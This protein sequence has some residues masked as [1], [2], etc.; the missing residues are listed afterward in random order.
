MALLLLN[1][2]TGYH[3]GIDWMSWNVGE[4][5][6]GVSN[7]PEGIHYIY[8]SA[9]ELRG[10]DCSTRS[11]KFIHFN[12]NQIHVWTWNTELETCLELEP[13]EA[14]KYQDGANRHEFDTNLGP[15]PIEHHKKWISLTNHIT[16]IT[17]NRLSPVQFTVAAAAATPT[18]TETET[19]SKSTQN[20]HQS[21]GRSFYTKL[22]GRRPTIIKNASDVTKYAFDRTQALSEVLHAIQTT[23]T[24]SYQGDEDLAMNELL[25]ELEYSFISFIVGQTAD[26]LEQWKSL[27]D[28]LCRC[29]DA[30]DGK[31]AEG[32]PLIPKA[33]FIVL[34][35]MLMAQLIEVPEDFFAG[36]L[37]SN[38]FLR[39]ALSSFFSLLPKKDGLKLSE[40]TQSRFGW[41][42]EAEEEDELF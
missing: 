41:D 4:K 16:N 40:L 34:L 36:D 38:N 5:F 14:L 29:E 21:T 6:M 8:W 25:G 30:M 12:P 23:S 22:P 26:G 1:F 33:H 2:P 7:V 17:L 27:I 31:A 15:Y 19:K 9:K 18:T 28:L 32:Y 39:P 10:S 24:I 42:V 35:E 13:T 11:G 20:N 37:S 3:F